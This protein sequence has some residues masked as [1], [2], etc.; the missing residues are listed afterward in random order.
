MIGGRAETFVKLILQT[1]VQGKFLFDAVNL[2]EKWPT[3][4]L[5]VELRR[6]NYA[7]AFCVV[8]VK[9]T[10]RKLDNQGRLRCAVSKADIKRL[11]E[12]HAPCYI[13]GVEMHDMRFSLLKWMLAF[14]IGQVIAI[15]GLLIAIANGAFH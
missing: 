7:K 11:A 12:F 4:D 10:E 5:Y 13:I 8:Q 2:G 6:G 3:L 1:E 14:W 15:S 9:A